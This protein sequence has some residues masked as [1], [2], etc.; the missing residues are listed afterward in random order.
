MILAHVRL[1]ES[2]G[3]RDVLDAVS[4]VITNVFAFISHGLNKVTENLFTVTHAT[5]ENPIKSLLGISLM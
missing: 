3:W 5:V 2:G 4:T 1:S